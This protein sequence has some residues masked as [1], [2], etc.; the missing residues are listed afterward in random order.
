ALHVLRW[1]HEER[2]ALPLQGET[3]DECGV[4]VAPQA[5]CEYARAAALLGRT[6]RDRIGVSN[7]YGWLTVGEQKH[8]RQP[9]GRRGNV[10]RLIHRA[11][12]VRAT[13]GLKF[14]QEAPRLTNVRCGRPREVRAEALNVGGERHDAESVFGMQGVQQAFAGSPRL[15][16]LGS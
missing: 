16:D 14:L 15:C 11:G 4:N 13:P 7:A 8:Q 3:L 9:S 5:E 1:R 10:Q 12:D 6:L 2:R